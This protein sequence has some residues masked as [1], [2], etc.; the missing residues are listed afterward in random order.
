[1]VKERRR[2]GERARDAEGGAAGTEPK[3]MTQKET[4]FGNGQ[5]GSQQAE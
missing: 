2:G 1:M 4:F 3:T 5:V